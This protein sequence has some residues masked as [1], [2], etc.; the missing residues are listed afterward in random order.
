MIGFEFFILLM[1]YNF[2][3]SC[4]SLNIITYACVMILIMDTYVFYKILNMHCAF[5]LSF[6]LYKNLFSSYEA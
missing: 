3:E 5:K 2:V 1:Y 4:I 6:K